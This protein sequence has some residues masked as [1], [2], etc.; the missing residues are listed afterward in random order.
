MYFSPVIP[1]RTADIHAGN[2]IRSLSGAVQHIIDTHSSGRYRLDPKSEFVVLYDISGLLDLIGVFRGGPDP[3]A[4]PTLPLAGSVA[5]VPVLGSRVEVIVYKTRSMQNYQQRDLGLVVS[6][7]VA[8]Y[9]G[10]ELDIALWHLYVP[11]KELK[12][13]CHKR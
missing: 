12:I 11:P 10:L 13:I 1:L 5:I 8:R 9:L 2:A 3:S 4:D 6:Q 7:N